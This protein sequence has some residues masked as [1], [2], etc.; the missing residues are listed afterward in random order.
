MI[1]VSLSAAMLAAIAWRHLQERDRRPLAVC[2]F[3]LLLVDYLPARAP[4]FTLDRPSIYDVLVLQPDGGVCELPL[5]LRDGFGETGRLDTRVLAYQTRHKRALTGGFLARLSP[6]LAAAYQNDPVLG[7]LVRL[8]AGL[9][10]PP[11]PNVDRQAAA[12]RLLGHGIRYVVVNQ[13]I[14]PPDLVAWVRANLPLRP[15]A[16]EGA[17]ALYAIDAAI[18]ESRPDRSPAPSHP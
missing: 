13:E 9:R 18:A 5:G 16:V 12:A 10:T 14:A 4:F 7:P 11:E 2:L 1:V 17:R 6:R 8:S 3:A 15:L